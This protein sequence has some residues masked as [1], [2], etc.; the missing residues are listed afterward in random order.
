MYKILKSVL[1]AHGEQAAL[2]G[3]CYGW[4]NCP[5]DGIIQRADDH[6]NSRNVIEKGGDFGR[7]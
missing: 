7:V 2:K 3:G 5:S 4:N 6:A 1:N